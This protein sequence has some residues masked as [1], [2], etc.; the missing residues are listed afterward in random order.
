MSAESQMESTAELASVPPSRTWRDVALASA[1]SAAA[2]CAL[3]AAVAVGPR[4][5]L[6]VTALLAAIALAVEK[7]T[8]SLTGRLRVSATFLPIVLG[9]VVAGP[10][11]GAAVSAVAFLAHFRS[12]YVRWWV[13]TVAAVFSAAVA[14]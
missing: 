2:V 10:I 14:G 8:V 5:P 11:C 12:P 4:P 9:L 1:Y 13:W 3:A 6:G 7:R